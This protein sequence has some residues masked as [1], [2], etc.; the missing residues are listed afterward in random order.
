MYFV[1][2]KRIGDPIAGFLR[3]I[4]FQQEPR[5]AKRDHFWQISRLV[6][7]ASPFW[8]DTFTISA[9]RPA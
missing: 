6:N 7:R 5:F 9:T 8:S 2:D 3:S 4:G 1:L